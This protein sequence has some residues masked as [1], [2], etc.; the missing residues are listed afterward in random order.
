MHGR[1]A[2]ILLELTA[3]SSERVVYNHK[4]WATRSEA[5]KLKKAIVA[6]NMQI[7]SEIDISH[8]GLIL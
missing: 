8:R 7:S 4:F 2:P 1:I 5:R 6:L 3:W